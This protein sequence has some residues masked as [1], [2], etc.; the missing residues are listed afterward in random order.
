[1]NLGS[2]LVNSHY[3]LVNLSRLLVSLGSLLVN[4]HYL[5]VS[6]IDYF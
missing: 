3:L 5:L 1:M 4:L 2:L 6:L